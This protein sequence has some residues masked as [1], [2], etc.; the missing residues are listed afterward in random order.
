MHSKCP[1]AVRTASPAFRRP[2]MSSIEAVPKRGDR[3]FQPGHE[4]E[5]WVRRRGKKGRGGVGTGAEGGTKATCGPGCETHREQKAQSC[6]WISRGPAPVAFPS[7]DLME[8]RPD[9]VHDQLT[10]TAGPFAL[11]VFHSRPRP[12]AWCPHF[13]SHLCPLSLFAPPTLPA[14]LRLPSRCKFKPHLF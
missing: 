5:P 12:L 6:S 9:L 11:G 3:N 13:F 14:W 10:S 2:L 8:A 7:S 4:A 1:P